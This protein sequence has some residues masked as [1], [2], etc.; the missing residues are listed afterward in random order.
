MLDRVHTQQGEDSKTSDE[1][2]EKSAAIEAVGGLRTSLGALSFCALSHHAAENDQQRTDALNGFESSASKLLEGCAL[3]SDGQPMGEITPATAG[4]IR[5]T[6]A[7]NREVARAVDGFRASM[8]E[9]R[10][11]FEGPNSPDFS[12]VQAFNRMIETSMR[13]A[14]DD[15]I[16]TLRHDIDQNNKAALETT[17]R[18]MVAI[19][20]AMD[21]ILGVST[22]VRLISINA[23]VEAARAGPAGV[24]FGVIAAEIQR[25]A[26]EIRSTADS[27]TNELAEM[28][29]DLTRGAD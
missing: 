9:L 20:K 21:D 17:G 4:W 24:G 23:S 15:I 6:V 28:R 19:E 14:L 16:R 29:R 5:K 8:K 3:L 12:R 26:G 2:K 1:M 11:N 18:A 10:Q 22:N 7:E 27:A 25:L 13:G